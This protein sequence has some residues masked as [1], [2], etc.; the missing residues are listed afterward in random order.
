MSIVLVGVRV[1]SKYQ[2]LAS[3][4]AADAPLT[5][6]PG[7]AFKI[8]LKTLSGPTANCPIPDPLVIVAEAMEA[9]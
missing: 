4:V 6:V 8:L 7:P 1:T 2:L 5:V 9:S 3:A